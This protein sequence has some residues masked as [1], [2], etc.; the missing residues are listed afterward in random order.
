MLLICYSLDNT[1]LTIFADTESLLPTGYGLCHKGLKPL[2]QLLHLSPYQFVIASTG[3]NKQPLIGICFSFIDFSKSTACNVIR[4]RECSLT[5]LDKLWY[6]YSHI[7]KRIPLNATTIVFTLLFFIVVILMPNTEHTSTS[8]IF[9]PS[10]NPLAR[11]RSVTMTDFTSIREYIF[12]FNQHPH[13][14]SLHNAFNNTYSEPLNDTVRASLF[15][16]VNRTAMATNCDYLYRYVLLLSILFYLLTF[17]SLAG[18]S[19]LDSLIE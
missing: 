4:F 2:Q 16:D 7:Y 15:I 19:H 14:E 5:L 11:S 18:N 12:Q 10:P 8:S 9:R 6:L 3:N 1:N 17:S 13:C